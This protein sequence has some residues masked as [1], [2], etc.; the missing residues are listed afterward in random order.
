MTILNSQS[1]FRIGVPAGVPRGVYVEGRWREQTHGLDQQSDIILSRWTDTRIE[2]RREAVGAPDGQFVLGV[3][4][5]PTRVRLL[6]G[7]ETIFDGVMA[8]GMTYVCRPSQIMHAEFTGP[9]DFLHLYV[10][11]GS[12]RAQQGTGMGSG[13]SEEVS[14]ATMLARDGLIDQL[15]Q[16]VQTAGDGEDE[17]YIETLARAIVM[18]AAQIRP[19]AARA[20]PLPKWRL[21]RVI[22]Y[23]EAHIS[24]VI[25]LNDVAAAAGLSRTHF[26]VQFRLA[27]GCTPHNFILMRRI[28]AA[29][30]LL[31]DTSDA[32][33]DVALTVGFQAQAHF[34][35]VFKRFVGETPGR[36]RRTQ[37]TE[38]S[39]RRKAA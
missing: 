13:M 37:F 9:A 31:L 16:A 18:R 7:P 12:I 4:L 30:R 32:L 23:I 3:A 11:G 21:R 35:T 6:S 19:R 20:L 36:W 39:Q 27:T 10:A 29:K 5:T 8:S 14:L 28:E 17:G 24:E 38:L 26:G 1:E 33:V 25:S 2:A 15:A 34:S 22:D